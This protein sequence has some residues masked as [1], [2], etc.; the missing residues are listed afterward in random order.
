MKI[1]AAILLVFTSGSVIAQDWSP[2][3]NREVAMLPLPVPLTDE[4][5]AAVQPTEAQKIN[6]L[7]RAYVFNN[8]SMV[9]WGSIDVSGE[10]LDAK[11][12]KT[13]K[14]IPTDRNVVEWTERNMLDRTAD[15]RYGIRSLIHEIVQSTLFQTK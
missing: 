9:G 14:I 13:E 6:A 15:G 12:V 2:I 3:D 7:K 1:I 8:N 11:V 10:N 5:L 4:E